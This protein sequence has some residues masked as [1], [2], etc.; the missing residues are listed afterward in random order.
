[1][2]QLADNVWQIGGFPPNAINVFLIDDVVIDASTRHAGRR[3]LKQLR[4]HDVGAHAL[5]HAHPDHQG[6]SK[7]ICT[8]LSVPFWV[9]ERDA[10][11]AEDPSLIAQRQPDHPI[12]R[13]IDKAFTG[14][15]HPVDRK[16]REGDAVG[17]FI[18]RN[19]PGHSRGHVAFWRESDRVLVAGDVL[20]TADSMTMIPGLHE[21]KAF[22]TDDPE[23]N[24]GSLKRLGELEPKLVLVGH[25]PPYRDT[26]KFVEFC[27]SV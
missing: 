12:A 3:I 16:L 17:S 18:V 5:T 15:G 20:N 4:G 13:L 19:V 11:A 14:P 23:T 22:F 2:K 24:R 1:M 21:P 10:D 8:E 26:K 6:A 9:G 27:E 25:G 7:R